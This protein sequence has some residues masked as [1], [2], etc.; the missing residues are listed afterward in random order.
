MYLVHL[1]ALKYTKELE[2]LLSG[3]TLFFIMHVALCLIIHIVKL[4][5]SINTKGTVKDFT[6]HSD[7][8]NISVVTDCF[9]NSLDNS[10]IYY[11]QVPSFLNYA[12]V[13]HN[14]DAKS[15]V[16]WFVFDKYGKNWNLAYTE[17]QIDVCSELVSA[18]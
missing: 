7:W 16:V 8:E 2:T 4:N 11:L 14:W 15:Q 9:Q 13:L 17:I 5:Y 6:D 18:T 10:Q 1:Q 12:A 3:T